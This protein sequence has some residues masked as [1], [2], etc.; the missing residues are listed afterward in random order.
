MCF[1]TDI[2]IGK[3]LLKSPP[4]FKHDPLNPEMSYP[5]AEMSSHSSSSFA[6]LFEIQQYL[7]RASRGH[8]EA[9]RSKEQAHGKNYVNIVD[10]TCNDDVA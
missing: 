4:T 5:N 2:E 10:T 6:N 7:V 9:T 3:L 8:N 1:L